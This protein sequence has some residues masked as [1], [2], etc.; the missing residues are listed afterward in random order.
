LLDTEKEITSRW[1]WYNHKSDVSYLISI[2]L[3]LFSSNQQNLKVL[4]D[5]FFYIFGYLGTDDFRSLKHIE[6]PFTIN[7]PYSQN[8]IK[9]IDIKSKIFNFTYKLIW[10]ESDQISAYAKSAITE[11][12]ASRELL[13]ALNIEFSVN[14]FAESHFRNDYSKFISLDIVDAQQCIFSSEVWDIKPNTVYEAW[15]SSI[16][17]NLLIESSNSLGTLSLKCTDKFL[18]SFK[19]VAFLNSTISE[20]LFPLICHDII[21]NYG[22]VSEQSNFI[23]SKLTQVMLS[24]NSVKYIPQAAKLAIKVLNFLLR[25][26]INEFIVQS[27]STSNKRGDNN[28]NASNKLN[29][30]A[31][32]FSKENSLS[33]F[34]LFL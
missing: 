12:T 23:A 1:L 14:F 19:D 21:T 22:V 24:T 31:N 8:L 9:V 32:E 18:T 5:D 27:T 34:S 2:L 10:D 11:V 28:S 20:M 17:Y 33:F 3:E 15:I 7:D 26:D 6:L 30:S 25:Q 4:Y 13:N 16:V 29:T